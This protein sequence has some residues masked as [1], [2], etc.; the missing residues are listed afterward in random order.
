MSLNRLNI[1]FV[2]WNYVHLFPCIHS[3]TFYYI[4]HEE[5]ILLCPSFGVFPSE[6]ITFDNFHIAEDETTVALCGKK[7]Q[8]HPVA[9]RNLDIKYCN[10][11]MTQFHFCLKC[12]FI[13]KWKIVVLPTFYSILLKELLK[14]VLKE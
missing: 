9:L 10:F 11:P 8:E 2:F 3:N 4:L 6:M 5:E 14:K 12:Y 13:R 7:Y 1:Q